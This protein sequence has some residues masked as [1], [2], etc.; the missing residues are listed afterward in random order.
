MLGL[1]IRSGRRRKAEVSK[2][3]IVDRMSSRLAFQRVLRV[4]LRAGRYC[5]MIDYSGKSPRF[6]RN[7]GAKK[8][9]GARQLVRQEWAGGHSRRAQPPQFAHGCAP[10]GELLRYFRSNLGGTLYASD[11]SV[12]A[13]KT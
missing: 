1:G 7:P 2:A 6:T 10:I 9:V 13:H 12:P 3:F 4:W 11:T 8:N 5:S